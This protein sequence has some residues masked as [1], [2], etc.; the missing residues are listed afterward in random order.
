MP[1][2]LLLLLL[3]AFWVVVVVGWMLLFRP[4]AVTE[5]R[6]AA[7]G[8]AV[9]LPAGATPSANVALIADPTETA[10]PA[11]PAAPPPT[12]ALTTPAALA[13][14]TPTATATLTPPA[15]PTPAATASPTPTPRPRAVV[16]VAAV[17]LRAEPRL[18][19][20][21]VTV[22]RQGA[23][24]ELTGAAADG[25]GYPWVEAVAADGQRGWVVAVALVAP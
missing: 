7:P 22:L 13:T 17:N 20:P 19:A 1:R 6:P 23:A 4:P 12:A 14:A 15:A 5:L 16:D 21:V 25:D 11:P 10:P 8:T 3:L 9:R 24:V 18:A 2:Q